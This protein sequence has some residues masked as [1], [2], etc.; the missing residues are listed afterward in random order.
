MPKKILA[1]NGSYRRS[2]ATAQAVAEVL[3]GA[4]EAGALTET[5]D[6][7]QERIEFCTNCRACTQ[8][9]G[10]KRGA[11]PIEDEM[12]ALLDR[13]EAADALVL[14]AP[15]NCFNLTAVTRRFMERLTV[16]AYWPW[17]AGGPKYRRAK[18]SKK[19]VLI[20]SSAMPAPLGRLF[21]GAMRALKLM[22][23]TVGAEPAGSMFIGMSSV[24]ERPELT[25][26]EKNKAR[27]LGRRLA[28]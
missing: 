8:Q 13:V 18:P 27:A 10:E 9:P 4:R 6:L 12:G 22:A 2:G 1:I 15:V 16:Y 3:E 17:G 11:C 7:A 14:A 19:A 24:R 21:T 20:T 23:R 25:A 28:A 26:A 5:V